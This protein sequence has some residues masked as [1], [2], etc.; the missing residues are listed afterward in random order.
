LTQENNK[1]LVLGTGGASKAV[2]YVLRQNNIQFQLVSRS[3]GKDTI[4]Y[5][6][7]DKSMMQAYNLIINCTPLGM[8]PNIE[9]FPALPYEQANEN[10]I[11]YDLVY[12]PEETVFLKKAKEQGATLANGFDMLIA[13]AEKNW[14]IWNE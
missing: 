3:A 1:A 14:E 5:E 11:F 13:Q 9:S 7:I 2:Q 4:T 8:V 12:K 6:A 10:H